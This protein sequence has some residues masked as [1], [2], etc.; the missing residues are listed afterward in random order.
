MWARVSTYEGSP[1][2]ID[3]ATTYDTE[4]IMPQVRQLDGFR[5]IY[6]LADR[7]TGR[8][9]SITLWADEDALHDFF[10]ALSPDSRAFR[11]LSLGVNLR[12][13]A[14]HA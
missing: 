5:G 13:A 7:D 8:T 11:F 4:K 3:D 6:A 2:V 14:R 9:M 1:D 10:S 12:A